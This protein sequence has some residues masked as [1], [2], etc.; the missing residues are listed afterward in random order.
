MMNNN[1]VELFSKIKNEDEKKNEYIF[2]KIWMLLQSTDEKIYTE[3]DTKAFTVQI[4]LEK[5]KWL[6]NKYNDLDN[7]IEEFLLFLYENKEIKNN[8]KEYNTLVNAILGNRWGGK[9]EGA[10]RPAT[11]RIRKTI[12]MTDEEYTKV[13]KY[14]NELRMK[15]EP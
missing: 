2:K 7:F 11:G 9:R 6:E 14:L 15:S 4:L 3:E 1:L 10:G 12:Y 8:K 5:C 13:K